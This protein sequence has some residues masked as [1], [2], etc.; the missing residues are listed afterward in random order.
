M[1]QNLKAYQV[2]NNASLH[3]AD[4]HQ[5]ITMLMRGALDR[6]AQAKGAIQRQDIDAKHDRI[7]KAIGILY[8]LQDGLDFNADQEISSNFYEL[9]DYMVRRLIDA[10]AEMS[11]E[12]IDECIGLLGPISE[13]WSNIPEEVKQD[14]IRQ[15]QEKHQVKE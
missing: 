10:G 1:R 12:P 15:Q 5:I 7:N 11:V 3:E 9:Y 8:G 13:A 4:S 6:M 2:N 14:V